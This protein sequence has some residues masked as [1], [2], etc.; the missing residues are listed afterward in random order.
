ML[1]RLK[2]QE[3]HCLDAF[4]KNANE[5]FSHPRSMTRVFRS[6]K[7]STEILNR[8]VKHIVGDFDPN[9]ENYQWKRN[10]FAEPGD[11]SK[12]YGSICQLH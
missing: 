4:H 5:I 9:P 7:Y 3:D 1:G 11:R 10:L 8:A 6:H 12:T 2:M